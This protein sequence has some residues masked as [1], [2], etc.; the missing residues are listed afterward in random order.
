[1]WR[2]ENWSIHKNFPVYPAINGLSG[3]VG[4][5]LILENLQTM[6]QNMHKFAF[7]ELNEKKSQIFNLH[8]KMKT[9]K[10]F[11]T[12]KMLIVNLISFFICPY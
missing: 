8:Y 11:I 6:M 1:M 5:I 9:G 2:S 4:Q 7:G 12:K 3:H 10:K